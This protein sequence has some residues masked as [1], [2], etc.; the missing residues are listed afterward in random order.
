[1]LYSRKEKCHFFNLLI[2]R[3]IEW[4]TQCPYFISIPFSKQKCMVLKF[5]LRNVYQQVPKRPKSILIW[6]TEHISTKENEKA[7]ILAQ[8]C[9]TFS[10]FGWE[11]TV[12]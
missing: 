6:V 7:D 4:N 5:A 9:A 12:L 11:G 3:H 2:D 8:Q 1:M 10:F